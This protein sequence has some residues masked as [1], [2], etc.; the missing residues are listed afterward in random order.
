E[1][2]GGYGAGLHGEAV[3]AG[4][5]GASR[6]AETRRLVGPELTARQKQLLARFSLP[7]SPRPEWATDDQLAVMRRDKK[8]AGGRLRFILPTRLG[9][10]RLFDDVPEEQVR[11]VLE[12]R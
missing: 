12:G 4:M 3:A 10:V 8:A 7:L 9:E 6:L 5:V 1:G 2:V 11:A